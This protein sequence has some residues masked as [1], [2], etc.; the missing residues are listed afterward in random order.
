[1]ADMLVTA[2]EL[3]SF[4]QKDLDTASATLSIEIATGLVQGAAE[5]R[6]VRVVDDTVTLDLD[7]HD[8]GLWLNLPERPVIS[9]GAVLVG[10]TAVT[11][12]TTQLRRGRLYRAYGW[13][14]ATLPSWSAPSTVTVTYTHGYADGD[15]KLQS[16]RAA[17]FALA[18]VA[19]ENATGAT[20]EQID[21][22]A[23]RYEAAAAR[24]EAAPAMK[25]AIRRQYGRPVG[26]ALLIRS[27]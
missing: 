10:A 2:P 4:L 3:A 6:I 12:F 11:D 9:V 22:Y 15:Q 13:R 18:A 8:C 23:V 17:T 19:Y 5:Q 14:S 1:V 25:A 7:E 26:S 27:Q 20:S 21:D 24:L 16:A